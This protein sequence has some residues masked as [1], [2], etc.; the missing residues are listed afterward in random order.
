MTRFF[1]FLFSAN[2]AQIQ[3]LSCEGASRKLDKPAC[4]GYYICKRVHIERRG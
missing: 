2:S 3:P 1:S 4:S